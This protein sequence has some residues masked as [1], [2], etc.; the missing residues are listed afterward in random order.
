MSKHKNAPAQ[1][2]FTFPAEIYA[3]AAH[4]AALLLAVFSAVFIYA[5]AAQAE[6]DSET[7]ARLSAAGANDRAAGSS[8]LPLPRF[9]TLKSGKV[10]M[11]VGPDMRKY[12]VTWT[13]ERQGLPV[14]I[15]QEYDNW[16]RIRD[17]DGTEG[18]VNAALL[19]GRRGAIIAPHSKSGQIMLYEKPDIASKVTIKA[20]PGVIG[21][22]KKCDGTW[23][24]L[25]IQGNY[26]YIQEN[27]LWGVYGQEKVE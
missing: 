7:L 5:H 23:C 15:I 24:E 27:Q 25:D 26:G 3:F 13:Y 14:E 11:R 4:A 16:R 20:D 17:V 18:W 10:N 12:P 9:V 22:I 8:D 2:A 1:C 21:R 6:T 19:S